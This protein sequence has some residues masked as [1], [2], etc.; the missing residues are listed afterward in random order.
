MYICLAIVS[1][2]NNFVIFKNCVYFIFS[3]K[4]TIDKDMIK[5]FK[6][7]Q[8]NEHKNWRGINVK[9]TSRPGID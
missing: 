3:K 6:A 7:V 2:Y 9:F 4:Q 8:E 1:I 5:K